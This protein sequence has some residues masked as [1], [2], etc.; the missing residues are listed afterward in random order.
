MG[1]LAA[2]ILL[3]LLSG[4]KPDSHVTLVGKLIVRQTTAPPPAG[5]RT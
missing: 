3:Q 2:E 4:E 1:R 5:R